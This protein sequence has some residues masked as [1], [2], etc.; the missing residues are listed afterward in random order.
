MQPTTQRIET[1]DVLRGLA[2]LGILVMN[3]QSFAMPMAAYLNPAAF[4]SLEGINGLVWSIG[5]LLT[6]QKMMALF[7][8]LFGAG[9]LLFCERAEASGRS[10]A[11]YY[12]RRNLWLVV[13]G[14]LHG[15]L[16]WSGDILFLYGICACLLYPLRRK[17]VRT[18]IILGVLA[19]SISS[20]LYLLTGVALNAMPPEE[21]T[22][23][24][25][26]GWQPAPQQMS[27]EIAAFQGNWV[28][29]M[30]AR[31]PATQEM[32]GLV[33]MMWGFWRAS[34]MMLLGMALYKTGII[35]GRA[36][37]VVY[38]RLLWL[39]LA[40]GLPLVAFGIFWNFSNDWQVSSMFTGSQFNYWGSVLVSLGWMALI[41][42]TLKGKRL[43]ALTDRLAATGRMAFSNY[44]MQTLICG[45]IFYGHGLGLIGQ[46]ERWGQILI[47]FGVWVLQLWLSPVWLRHFR[48][49][50]LEWLW[51]S[52]TYGQLQPFRR[53]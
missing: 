28:T 25:L 53:S 51:R 3:I 2:V 4:G 19:L 29:Q 15:Y 32:Q 41:V 14:L 20:A 6:D 5:H 22:T 49:G 11:K 21:V 30:Q 33:L 50:P 48:F 8:M 13:F 47:V 16:L 42:L 45:F 39:G 31:V 9:I 38:L 26:P 7:S 27:E 18:L 46:V 24:I 23:T 1:L 34:G 52:L 43:T 35:T 44:I 17:S 37:R 10:V 12:Y 40:A 36:E